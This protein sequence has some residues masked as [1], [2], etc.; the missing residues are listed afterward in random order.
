MI[1]SESDISAARVVVSIRLPT[2]ANSAGKSVSEAINITNT[3]IAAPV[4]SPL[5]N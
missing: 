4:A 2:I 1:N 3:P 5:M